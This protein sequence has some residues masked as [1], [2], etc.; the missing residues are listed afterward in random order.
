MIRVRFP[1]AE[2]KR[3]ALGKVAGRCSF[4]SWAGGEMLVPEDALSFLA[5]E[6]IPFTVEGLARY[7]ELCPEIGNSSGHKVCQSLP[8]QTPDRV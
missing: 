8:A 4:K 7:E 2:S 6:G 5:V 3:A 1:N